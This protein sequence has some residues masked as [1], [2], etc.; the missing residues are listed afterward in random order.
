M[1]PDAGDDIFAPWGDLGGCPIL[2]SRGSS[3]FANEVEAPCGE[4]LWGN[5]LGE[6]IPDGWWAIQGAHPARLAGLLS[7]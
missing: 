1:A 7:M 5:E 2:S 4:K 3:I 6:G